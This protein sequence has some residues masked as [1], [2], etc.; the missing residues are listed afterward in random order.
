VMPDFAN[1][2]GNSFSLAERE[3]VIAGAEAHDLVLL[4]DAAYTDLRYCGAPLPSLLALDLERSRDID[5]SRVIHCGTFSKT[6]I[7]GLRAGWVVAARAVIEKMGLLKQASDFHTAALTQMVL[8]DVAQRLPQS[9][10]A[11]LCDTYGARLKAMLDALGRH[12]PKGVSWTSPEGG[13]FVWVT[14]PDKMDAA[15]LLKDA[16]AEGI[17]FVPGESFFPGNRLK[18]TMRLNFT[19]CEPDTIRDGIARLGR[20]IAKTL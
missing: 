11:M 15:L 13:M 1:P 17:A 6:V 19:A 16:L 12:M 7:P 10:V 18:N 3:A 14:L 5:G 9:H 4:E 8:T 20:L 2:T